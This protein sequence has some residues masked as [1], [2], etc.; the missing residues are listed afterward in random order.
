MTPEIDKEL[1][2]IE[3]RVDVLI[4]EALKLHYE[5]QRVL[6]TTTK[7]PVLRMPRAELNS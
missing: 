4:E 3:H 5:L 2:R 1:R 6:E 7:R